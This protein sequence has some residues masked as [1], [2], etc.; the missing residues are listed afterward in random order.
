MSTQTAIDKTTATNEVRAE[1]TRNCATYQPAVDII[2]SPD[3]LTLFADMPGLR[4]EDVDIHFENG[5]LTIHGTVA[6]RQ[7]QQ[8]RFL[9]REYGV[10]DFERSF[11]IGETIDA[12]K[13]SAEYV[14]G[15]LK[16]HLPK[17]AAARPRKIEV[18]GS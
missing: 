10:G 16:L 6:E 13:I 8:T 15:V 12:E 17:V 18:K 1:R 5:M 7:P 14:D 9:R 3:E 2:E 4:P 11:R